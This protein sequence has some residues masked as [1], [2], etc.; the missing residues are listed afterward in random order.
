[1][2]W[3]PEVSDQDLQEARERADAILIV[4]DQYEL[5]AQAMRRKAH[6]ARRHYEDLLL[7][8]QGQMVLPFD[9]EA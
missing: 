1:M 3:S 5:R 2:A 6:A 7:I 8:H 9:E 4:A